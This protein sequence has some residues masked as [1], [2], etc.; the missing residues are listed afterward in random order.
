MG[1]ITFKKI[2]LTTDLSENAEAAAPYAVELARRQGGTIYLVH[3]FED[4]PYY[5]GV[6][7][8]FVGYDPA[9]WIKASFEERDQRLAV[10]AKELAKKEGLQVIPCLR[11]GNAVKE[12]LALLEEQRTD[13]VVISTHGRTG[14]SHLFLGSVAERLVRLSP[15][16]VLTV[17][18]AGLEDKAGGKGKN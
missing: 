1:E 7:D 10:S 16:P 3:V 17:R 9:A 6:S 12:I 5:L 15:C 4:A 11:Q 13:C 14:L 2:V 18:P 8:G